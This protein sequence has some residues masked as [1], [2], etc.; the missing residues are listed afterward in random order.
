M[1]AP[2][3]HIM[4]I[5]NSFPGRNPDS[6]VI[7]MCW[8]E[9]TNDWKDGELMLGDSGFRNLIPNLIVPDDWPSPLSKELRKVRCRVENTFAKIKSFGI[10]KLSL[11][12]QINHEQG[13]HKIIDFHQ[14]NW[15]LVAVIVNINQSLGHYSNY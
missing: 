15:F 6:T 10:C 9:W 1:A 4:A 11:R 2:D 12:Y 7:K 3:G 5:S 14:R 8:H 13:W